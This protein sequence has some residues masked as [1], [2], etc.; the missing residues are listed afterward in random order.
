VKNSIEIFQDETG[1]WR[2]RVKGGN[3]EIVAASEGYVSESNARRGAENLSLIMMPETKA[4]KPEPEE[5]LDAEIAT[6]DA[7]MT[8]EER[9]ER[10]D[11][12]MDAAWCYLSVARHGVGFDLRMY[13]MAWP[14]E[15]EKWDPGTKAENIAKASRF[16]NIARRLYNERTTD[17]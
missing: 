8:D 13:P 17:G 1:D 5:E 16:L 15:K 2:F 6:V 9:A 12:L 3:G 7:E 11:D 10:I 4:A 14:W